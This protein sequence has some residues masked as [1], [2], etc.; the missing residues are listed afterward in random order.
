MA[1]MQR[2]QDIALLNTLREELNDPIL[3]LPPEEV[4]R[5]RAEMMKIRARVFG[6]GS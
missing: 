3:Q 4:A 1:M 2:Q 5:I 6:S